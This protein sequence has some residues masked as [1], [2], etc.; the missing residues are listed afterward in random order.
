MSRRK[1]RLKTKLRKTLVLFSIAAVMTGGLTWFNHNRLFL[2]N[3]RLYYWPMYAGTAQY[4][5]ERLQRNLGRT[6]SRAA[7]TPDHALSV[8]VLVYHGIRPKTDGENISIQ[9]FTDQML[10]LKRDGWHAVSLQDFYD[11]MRRGKQLP[12][13]SILITFDDGRRDSF[14][15][16]QPLLSALDF[17]AT[18]FVITQSS[19]SAEANKF[20]LNPD[21]LKRMRDTGR[22][23][24]QP[25]A[26]YGH[27]LYPINEKGKLGHF[28]DNKLWLEKEQRLETDA[29][30]AV[31]TLN[32]LKL[33][34]TAMANKLGSSGIAFA[35]PFNEF[36]HG[37]VNYA[38]A[39]E[40]LLKNVGELFP[41]AFYQIWPNK[42]NTQNYP[43]DRSF[44]MKR[45]LVDAKMDVNALMQKL[46]RSSGK[47]LPYAN[48]MTQATDDWLETWG[49]RSWDGDGLTIR[50]ETNSTGASIF[51]DGGGGWSNYTATARFRLEQGKWSRLLGR[52][53]D[54]KNYVTCQFGET[55]VTVE[56]TIDG[57][58]HG[59]N[60]VDVPVPVNDFQAGIRL[61]GNKAECLVNGQPA[62]E[63]DE[64]SPQLSH[65]GVGVSS[66]D[67][68]NNNSQLRISQLKV[69]PLR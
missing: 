41:M 7:A 4:L 55:G 27:F 28:Y 43:S 33:A 10:A 66:Y 56:Q 63:S 49:M 53:R 39:Q 36:G 51:L 11:F 50:A 17:R 18:M 15:T 26:A 46:N 24:L 37:T 2:M 19:F 32:D 29:E 20:Y 6:A 5:L 45:I 21:D 23:D 60:K 38:G 9:T 68:D 67:E 1:Q 22:W 64:L 30:F 57:K 40:V 12:A 34:K 47:T 62:A 8:P 35:F 65:G 61:T 31:R 59:L 3:Q 58:I 25:H 14:Y 69:D 44:M 54:D 16:V 48:A 13:R 42:G 52:F